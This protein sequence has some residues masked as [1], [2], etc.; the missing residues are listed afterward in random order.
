M[1][2]LAKSPTFEEVLVDALTDHTIDSNALY[3]LVEE[4]KTAI[5]VAEN[6]AKI[7]KAAALDPLQSPDPVSARATMENAEFKAARLKS[8]LPRLQ[9]RVVEVGDREEIMAWHA[10]LDPLALKVTEAAT[11]LTT[12]YAK[13]T[14]ELVP[15]FAEIER[16]DSQVVAVLAAKPHHASGYL[17]SVEL[18]A[19]G[20]KNFSTYAHEIMQMKLPDFDRE[21]ELLWPPNRQLDYSNTIPVY[22][23]SHSGADWWKTQQQDRAS[24]SDEAERL[25]AE[26]QQ[27]EG[28]KRET[29]FRDLSDWGMKE[30]G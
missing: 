22:A 20:L 17:R 8:I 15:L 30:V 1:T 3:D 6:D 13:L 12:V 18:T 21:N 25:N 4:T 27:A 9:E 14:A 16:L 29:R 2:T 5:T 19:R 11:K 24:K 10:R 7:A 28:A 26:H 23:K